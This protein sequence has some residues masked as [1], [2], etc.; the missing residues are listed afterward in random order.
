MSEAIV[1]ILERQS[2][3]EWDESVQSDAEDSIFDSDGEEDESVE[4]EEDS[5]SHRPDEFH[6]Q[7]GPFSCSY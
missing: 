2:Q 1:A 3:Q 7:V 5:A 4:E 6:R